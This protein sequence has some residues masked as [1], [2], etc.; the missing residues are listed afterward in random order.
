METFQSRIERLFGLPDLPVDERRKRTLLFVC[1][2]VAVPLI[3]VYGGI[4]WYEGRHFEGGIILAV[5]LS[6]LAI[7]Y[8]AK[9]LARMARAYRFSATLVF[10][11]LIYELGT[12]GG[13]G[14]AFLWFYFFPIALFFMFGRRE[15]AVWVVA[16]LAVMVA[17]LILDLGT[18]D[19]GLGA[20]TRFLLTYGI[21]VIVSF[22]LESSRAYYY[23]ALLKEKKSLEEALGQVKTLRGLF[24]LCAYCKNV[25]DDR[26]YWSQIEAYV[27]EHSD[28][29]FS[30]GICP[31]CA[32]KYYPE[33]D[34]Y[35]QGSESPEPR[36]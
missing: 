6:L 14:Y 7:A 17:F 8:L 13:E 28:A 22:A 30:H 5:A 9:N 4:D 34:L 35:G 33:M 23:S 26:G 2:L 18:Y 1:I 11:L 27:S 32:Q 29:D 20:S 15:G 21:V 10:V 12:G 31:E 3:S 36:S 25:R 16:T 24:P 19:Y